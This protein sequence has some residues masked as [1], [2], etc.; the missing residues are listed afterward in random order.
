MQIAENRLII[1]TEKL[2][3]YVQHDASTHEC[4]SYIGGE[5]VKRQSQNHAERRNH[6]V[7]LVA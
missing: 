6:Q 4:S 3:R 1:G 2:S 5:A 7:A